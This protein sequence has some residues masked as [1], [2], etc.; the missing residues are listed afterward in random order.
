MAFDFGTVALAGLEQGFH[1][2]NANAANKNAA[3]QAALNRDWQEKMSSTAYQRGM[4]DM[5]AAGL[6]PILAYQRGPASSPS[7]ATASTSTAGVA[8]F[9]SNAAQVSI[10]R[11]RAAAEIENMKE[12][13]DN[14]RKQNNLISA[15]TLQATA[16]AGKIA[17]ET[18]VVREA[19]Q[20]SEADAA[21]ARDVETYRKSTFGTVSTWANE[22]IKDLSPWVSSAGEVNRMRPQSSTES[23]SR[24]DWGNV[25]VRSRRDRR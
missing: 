15:Q 4:A 25:T 5:K 21:R 17:A 1:M 14:I 2:I 19:L 10:N 13:N 6:N 22:L 3:H 23:Y 7:G 20:R 24:D 16:A 9:S 12:Q 11:E 8:P 18:A